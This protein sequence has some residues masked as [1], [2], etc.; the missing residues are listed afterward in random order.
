MTKILGIITAKTS[1][2]TVEQ[3]KDTRLADTMVFPIV[4]SRTMGT[5]AAIPNGV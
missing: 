1:T 2:T 4:R 5:S 3:G